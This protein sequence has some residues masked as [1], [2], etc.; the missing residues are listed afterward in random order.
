MENFS[1]TDELINIK[2]NLDNTITN[3]ENGNVSLNE[4]GLQLEKINEK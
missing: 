2:T 3:N 4:L 1:Q